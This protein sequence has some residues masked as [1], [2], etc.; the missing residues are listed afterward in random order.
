[1]FETLLG[2]RLLGLFFAYGGLVLAGSRLGN[3]PEGPEGPRHGFEGGV[4][5]TVLA[6]TFWAA[7][8]DHLLPAVVVDIS[9]SG[10][11]LVVLDSRFPLPLGVVLFG[12]LLE[13]GRR[14]PDLLPWILVAPLLADPGFLDL[15]FLSGGTMRMDPREGLPNL[16]LILGPILLLAVEA[17]WRLGSDKPAPSLPLPGPGSGR[18]LPGWE[19]LPFLVGGLFLGLVPALLV[20]AA[21]YN[22]S[23][24]GRVTVRQIV[25][26]SLLAA[27]AQETA[28]T[29]FQVARPGAALVVAALA[30]GWA[31]AAARMNPRERTD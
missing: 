3:S 29:G 14:V 27:L 22:A 4:A 24:T 28:E 8:L 1:M 21:W 2:N 13:I 18:P 31:M 16:L 30:A 25:L 23:K 5:L 19:C 17:P 12:L 7:V 15:P 11:G 6:A 20:S 10:P 26:V 9:G